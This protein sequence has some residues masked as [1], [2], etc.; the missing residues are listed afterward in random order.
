M[1][2]R[3]KVSW[4]FRGLDGLEEELALEDLGGEE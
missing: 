3:P 2:R 4:H 1:A